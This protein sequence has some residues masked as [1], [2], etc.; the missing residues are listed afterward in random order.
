MREVVPEGVKKGSVPGSVPQID[1]ARG[2]CLTRRTARKVRL[3]YPGAIYH[4]MNRGDRREAIFHDDADRKLFLAT[5]AETCQ[6]TEGLKKQGWEE[7]DLA[8]R[9]KGDLAKVSLAMRV[10]AETTMTLK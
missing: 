4:L 3:E 8:S 2:V 5:R 6:K 10:R 1:S 7:A 9:P